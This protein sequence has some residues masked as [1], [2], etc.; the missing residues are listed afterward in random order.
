M[1]TTSKRHQQKCKEVKN[2][3]LISKTKTMQIGSQIMTKLLMFIII[4]LIKIMVEARIGRDISDIQGKP[5]QLKDCFAPDKDPV[6]L[7]ARLPK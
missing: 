4:I 7:K 6:L 5:R 2:M 1:I 3:T